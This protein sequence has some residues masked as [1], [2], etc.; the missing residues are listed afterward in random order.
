MSRDD[1]RSTTIT[2]EGV[3]DGLLEKR[4]KKRIRHYP[5]PRMLAPTPDQRRRI[6][7]TRRVWTTGDSLFKLAEEYYSDKEY[8][9]II[10]WY[11]FKPT[12]AHFKL[13]DIVFIPTEISKVLS[14]FRST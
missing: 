10:A 9:Y 11:N 3:Y 7:T 14:N 2:K 8:W 12:D 5:T 6:A 13:G 1:S 4:R